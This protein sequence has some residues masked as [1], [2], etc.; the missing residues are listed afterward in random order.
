MVRRGALVAIAVGLSTVTG[1]AVAGYRLAQWLPMGRSLPGTYVG[2]QLQPAERTLEGWLQARRIALRGQEAFLVLPDGDFRP[3]TFGELGVELDVAATI[4]AVHRHSTDGSFSERV[5]RAWHARQ[6]QEEVD[7]VWQFDPRQA[8][9]S[10]RQLAP[11]VFEEPVNAR[12]DLDAHERVPAQPG[13][14]LDVPATVA[15]IGSGE[16]TEFAVFPVVTQPL[17]PSVTLEQ[18]STVDVTQVLSSFVTDFA[19]TG[20]GRGLNIARAARYLEGR[21]LEPGATVSF[22][23][24]VGPR[25]LARGFTYAPEIYDDELTSGV[26]GGVCQV[27]STLHAAAVLGGLEI[28]RRRSH[29]RPSDY[30]K[31]GLDAMVIH[32]EVDLRLRNPYER[33]LLIHAFVRQPGAL[34]IELLGEPPPV[35]VDYR[36]AVLERHDFYRRIKTKPELG[37]KSVRKQRGNYGYDV[38][39]TVTLRFSDGQE[40]S[41]RYHSKYRPTPEVYWVGPSADQDELPPL[42]EGAARTERDGEHEVAEAGAEDEASLEHDSNEA[43]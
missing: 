35:R 8:A 9:R 36:Y 26:G 42:P 23:D 24:L 11:T 19:G 6:G 16:R 12:L 41:R 4:A 17:A 10:L 14:E 38:V 29:S 15:S 34:H 18:L 25:I 3:T 21:I 32:G 40:R 1:A 43:G 28:V 33:S 7:L 31:L 30:I 27:A 2:G 20:R 39:S 37:S 13:H 22:N 5:W